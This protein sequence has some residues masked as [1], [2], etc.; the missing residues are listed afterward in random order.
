MPTC[1]TKFLTHLDCPGCG[2]LRAT[3]AL[4]HGDLRLALRDNAFLVLLSPIM[5]WLLTRA[6]QGYVTDRPTRVPTRLAG[7][8]LVVGVAWAIVRNLPNWPWKPISA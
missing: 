4:L 7:T 6:A 5:L 2:G 1:P 3:H 8:I